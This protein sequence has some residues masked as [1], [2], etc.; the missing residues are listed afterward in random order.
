M[1]KEKLNSFFSFIN[2]LLANKR[3]ILVK[4]VYNYEFKGEIYGIKKQ[5]V[6][7]YDY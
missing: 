4:E 1:K 3:V 5:S 2:W 6:I 7:V